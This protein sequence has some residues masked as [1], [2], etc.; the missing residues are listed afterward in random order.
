MALSETRFTSAVQ[1]MAG[2]LWTADAAGEF[3]D[4]QPGWAQLTG[5]DQAGYLGLGW[6]SA[7]HPDDAQ[8]AL[9]AWLQ[10]VS[11][12]DP[13]LHEHRVLRHD[14]VWRLCT[15]RAIPVEGPGGRVL[16]WVGVHTDVTDERLNQLRLADALRQLSLALDVGEIGVWSYSPHHALL[17]WDDRMHGLFG[18]GREGGVPYE[19]MLALVHEDDRLQLDEQMRGAGEGELGA[20][21]EAEFRIRPGGDGASAG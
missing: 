15:V 21:F 7:L 4:E 1:A 10:A 14:G 8:G 16:E 12:R 11:S 20:L 17:D 5:Q 19:R 2:V 13:F 9:D 3:V 18:L 6:L